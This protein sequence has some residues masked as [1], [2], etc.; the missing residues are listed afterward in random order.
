MA[1]SHGGAVRPKV[2]T[3]TFGFRY[4]FLDAALAPDLG[5]VVEQ[6]A[7]LGLDMLQ[8]CENSRPLELSEAAWEA[9]AARAAALGLEIELGCKT[10]QPAVF[11]RYLERAARLPSRLLRVVLEEEEGP[12]PGRAQVD[13]FLAAAWRMLEPAG[14]RLA[15]EN[16]FDVPGEVLAAAAEAYPADRVGF[17][18]DT[19]NSLRNFESPETVFRLL[20]PR[21]F[22]YHLKDFTVEGDKLGFRVGGAPLGAGRLDLDG[23]LD[24]VLASGPEPRI[25]VENWTPA[26][27]DRETDVAEDAAWLRRSFGA[28]VDALAA[29]GIPDR[30]RHGR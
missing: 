8:V 12:P 15:I 18:I 5:C 7:A 4:L 29:R 28:L 26:T 10:V 13:A 19:A 27:G 23:I 3:T 25:L 20:G 17:C 22:C 6:A 14:A 1:G 30:W 11:E 21:A 16:H 9:V 2:G 24:R